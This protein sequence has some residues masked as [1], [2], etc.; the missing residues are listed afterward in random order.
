[1]E[2]SKQMVWLGGAS[3]SYERAE[4]TLA[5]IGRL[6]IS[7]SSVWQQVQQWGGRL[8]ALAEAE[9]KE[10][11]QELSAQEMKE[12][13]AQSA[14]AKGAALDGAIIHLRGEGWKELKVGCVFDIALRPSKNKE[15][16]KWEEKAHATHNRYVSHLGGP[17]LFGQKL[18]AQARHQ[19]WLGSDKTLVLGDGAIWIWNLASH[20]FA[21]SR[22]LVDWYHATEHLGKAALL[23]HPDDPVQR[24]NWYEAQKTILYAGQAQEVADN[25]F[26]LAEDKPL[27]LAEM[28]AT[29]AG[30]LA[31]NHQRMAYAALRQAGFP[32]GS[33]MVESGCKQFKA[34]FDG[35]GMRWS[36]SGAQRLL[37]VRAAVMGNCFDDAWHL[38]HS[39]PP[40]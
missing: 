10:G 19:G 7:D 3:D 38:A 15:T 9:M 31:N 16:G 1:M 29:E 25:L 37:P 6:H 20:H 33:G 18:W 11:Q 4:E 27:A 30:Y 22:Q 28:L 32:I 5:R 40:N 2:L 26:D 17:E 23:L 8:A 24:H 39:L 14:G 13:A 36:R 34:R 12:R 21:A 35:P